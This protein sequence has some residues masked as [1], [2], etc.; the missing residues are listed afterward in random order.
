MLY[1]DDRWFFYVLAF[2]S[3]ATFKYTLD[4]RETDNC[5]N[6]NRKHITQRCYLVSSSNPDPDIN[7]C[8]NCEKTLG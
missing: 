5:K 6:G 7:V 4:E 3:K 1:D 8:G 2:M